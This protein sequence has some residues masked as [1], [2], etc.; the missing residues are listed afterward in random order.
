[1]GR[2]T[3]RRDSLEG[4][5]GRKS[6]LEG[7]RNGANRVAWRSGDGASHPGPSARRAARSEG[8]ISQ[9]ADASSNLRGD[10]TRV[11]TPRELVRLERGGSTDKTS[12]WRLR[13]S[14]ARSPCGSVRQR[15]REARGAAERGRGQ[16]ASLACERGW[17]PG[18]MRRAG[19]SLRGRCLTVARAD[20]RLRAPADPGG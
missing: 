6:G 7:E 14:D 18:G 4:R 2:S 13:G 8:R 15:A 1:M 17:R 11:R 20:D 12:K 19:A 10:S 16:H 9:D 5:D 3:P